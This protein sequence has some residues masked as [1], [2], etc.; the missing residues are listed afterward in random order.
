MPTRTSTTSPSID[1]RSS[2]SP[3]HDM[4]DLKNP[5]A[6]AERANRRK[7]ALRELSAVLFVAVAT[8]PLAAA[9][10]DAQSSPPPGYEPGQRKVVGLGL[11]PY[12]PQTPGLPGGTTV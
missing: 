1:T 5:R 7:R 6:R 3:A 10:D 4:T 11:S 9:A 8:T 12:A 2:P